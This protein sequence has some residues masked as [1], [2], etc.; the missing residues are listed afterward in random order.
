MG[1][2]V[3][4]PLGILHPWS[5]D[6]LSPIVPASASG[7]SGVWSTSLLGFHVMSHFSS[8][9]RF[10]SARGIDVIATY[11]RPRWEEAGRGVLSWH[12]S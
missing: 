8:H 5:A 6:R 3:F 4:L 7:A 9:F 12:S 1:A 2:W 10:W 11:G